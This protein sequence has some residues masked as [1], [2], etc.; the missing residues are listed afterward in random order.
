VGDAGEGE[1][2]QQCA[3]INKN[4][5]THINWAAVVGVRDPNGQVTAEQLNENVDRACLN[6]AWFVNSSCFWDSFRAMEDLHTAQAER[7]CLLT[8][9]RD[10]QMAPSSLP[11]V[12]VSPI[13]GPKT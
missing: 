1:K 4:G 6:R 9:L 11:P 5:I 10:S 12:G 13:C 3:R 7:Y 2:G 8:I